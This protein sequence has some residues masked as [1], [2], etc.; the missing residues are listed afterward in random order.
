VAKSSKP[1]SFLDECKLLTPRTWLD[2]LSAED[3]E[4]ILEV[5]RAFQAGE[6]CVSAALIH[7]QAIKRFG[8]DL[9]ASRFR[10]WIKEGKT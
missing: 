6:L 1:L 10:E 7:K 3:R 5:R 4:E 8:I 9:K 2:K